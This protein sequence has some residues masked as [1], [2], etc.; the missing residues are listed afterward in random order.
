MDSS[1]TIDYYNNNAQAFTSS[2]LDITFSDIQDRFLQHLR[3]NALILDFGCGTGRD[4]RY[5]LQ[6]GY[7]VEAC[8]GSVEMVR[9]ATQI[10][11]IPVRQMM[12]SEL[13]DCERYDGIWACA[14]I[15][16]VPFTEL[17]D[18]FRRMKIA[19]KTGG[20]L[21][22]SFKYGQFEGIRNGRC[23]TDMDEE[24][25][26]QILQATEPL[27]ILET[28]TTND[29]RPGREEEKWLNAILCKSMRPNTAQMK[30]LLPEA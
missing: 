14:S 13:D 6:K 15:L 10:T 26:G 27:E 12:F 1:Q 4:S 2:T 16:H 19:V 24:R 17:P 5:F 8:D 9:I 23:F 7:R 18:I 28:W 3:K 20:I 29:V 21:Y 30:S 22:V 25:L 11:G